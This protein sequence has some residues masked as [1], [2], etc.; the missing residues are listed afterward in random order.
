LQFKLIYFCSFK[1]LSQLAEVDLA[2]RDVLGAYDSAV[3]Q[4]AS[5]APSSSANVGNAHQ[6]SPQ[7]VH[8]PPPILQMAP[9]QGGGQGH[10]AQ[11]SEIGNGNGG[12]QW[13]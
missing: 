5:G 1:Q 10:S 6:N 4:V 7:P 12:G 2:I 13:Q 8:P 9:I 3:Q 11:H